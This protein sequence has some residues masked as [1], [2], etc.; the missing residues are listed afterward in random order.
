MTVSVVGTAAI[1]LWAARGGLDSLN[2]GGKFIQAL[3]IGGVAVM[4]YRRRYPSRRRGQPRKRR[5]R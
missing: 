4:L 1:L 3:V 5:K 2:G